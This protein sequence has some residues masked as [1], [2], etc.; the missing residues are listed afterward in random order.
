MKK[1]KINSQQDCK[2]FTLKKFFKVFFSSLITILLVG[3]IAFEVVVIVDQ[4]SQYN[5][6]FVSYRISV[7]TS[8]SMSAIDPSNEDRLENYKERINKGDLIVSETNINYEDIKI[9]DVIIY[10]NGKTL[11]CHR[12][13]NKF[14]EDNNEFLITQGDANNV[15]D[16]IISFNQ[17]KGRVIDVIPYIGYVNLYL[18]SPYGVLAI[19]LV[20]LIII[21]A[22]LINEFLKA[23]EN[24]E[25]KDSKKLDV[26]NAYIINDSKG[27]K[28]KWKR[29]LYFY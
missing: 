13:I 25:N 9:N 8:D 22:L 17:V 27:E 1:I 11:V 7:V 28:T 23:K 24:N 15:S 14:S 21:I 18:T 2:K 20:I 16:G 12:V 29:E 10:F 26:S 19:C 4:A 6:D 3:V 5:V